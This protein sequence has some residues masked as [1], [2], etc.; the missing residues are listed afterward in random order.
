MTLAVFIIA[1]T[2]CPGRVCATTRVGGGLGY[3]GGKV[4]PGESPKAAALREAAEEGWQFPVDTKLHFVVQQTIN[5][6]P[7]VWYSTNARPTRLSGH[8]EESRG[9]LPVSELADDMRKTGFGNGN[10]AVVQA[11][12]RAARGAK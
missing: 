2:Q 12:Y 8:K 5:G 10:R 7:V 11:A 9:I 1:G 4:D 6:T 3:P